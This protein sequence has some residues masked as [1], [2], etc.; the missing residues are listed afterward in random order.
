MDQGKIDQLRNEPIEEPMMI[1]GGKTAL[2]MSGRTLPVISPID[3]QE[4]AQIPDA[5]KDDVD[6][7]VSAA[8]LSFERA[9][10][11][12]DLRRLRAKVFC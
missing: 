5:D 1:I 3:G 2:A 7:A 9:L 4:I 10:S 12:R 6:M 11:G 8:K